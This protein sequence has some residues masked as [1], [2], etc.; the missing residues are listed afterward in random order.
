[1]TSRDRII[2]TLKGEAC[3]PIVALTAD[4]AETVRADC[5]AAG[6]AGVLTKPMTRA[7]LEAWI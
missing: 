5:E 2:M 3:P 7:Q 6:F 1:M 4:A